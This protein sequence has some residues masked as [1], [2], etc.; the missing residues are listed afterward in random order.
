MA[1]SY[2]SSTK[3]FTTK[4][5]GPG[6][7]IS[8]SH[9]NDLQDEVV[10]IETALLDGFAHVV[11]PVANATYDLGT[12]GLKW[13]DAY[14]SRNVT[15]GGTTEFSGDGTFLDNVKATFGTGGDADMYYDGTDLVINPAVVGAGDL[16]IPGASIEFDD[17]EG[18]TLGT[19]KDATLRY[20][21]T[22]LVI[23][24][25][26][27]GSGHAVLTAGDLYTTALTDYSS[28]STVVGWTSFSTKEIL[29]KKVGKFIIVVFQLAG[30]SN[31]TGATFTLPVAAKAGPPAVWSFALGFTMDNGAEGA[32]GRGSI[33]ASGTTVTLLKSAGGAWTNS[34]TKNIAGQF[35]YEAAS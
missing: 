16:V 9:V 5:D 11:K 17:S 29:Y 1:A 25:Q 3:S 14:F 20:D 21:G 22:N 35:F 10:A 30:T 6:N 12:S 18:V 7:T 13:R 33:S 15:I 32:T 34:G 28:S 19:G 8:A 31:A 27:V 2:P 26:A 4:S 24:P 23:N